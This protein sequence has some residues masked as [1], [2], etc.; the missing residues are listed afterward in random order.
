MAGCHWRGRRTGVVVSFATAG[1]VFL[2]LLAAL[3]PTILED[4]KAP[5]LL[6]EAAG[7]HNL[8]QEIRVGTFEYTRP[9]LVFYCQR[10]VFDVPAP[11]ETAD[12][13]ASP[14]PACLFLPVDYY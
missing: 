14:L 11:I 13:L 10:E 5:K 9:S 2:A 1:G 4:Q 7:A 12:F 3:G 6:V 8:D